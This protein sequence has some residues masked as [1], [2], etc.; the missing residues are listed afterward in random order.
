LTTIVRM[1][2][3]AD[4]VRTRTAFFAGPATT[5]SV[6]TAL[7]S[8]LPSEPDITHKVTATTIPA[9]TNQDL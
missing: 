8:E 1:T 7:S 3:S 9:E 5:A 2:S 6:A 4:C